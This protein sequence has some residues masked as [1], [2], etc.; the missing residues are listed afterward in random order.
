MHLQEP[1]RFTASSSQGD[2]D[3]EDVLHYHF[4]TKTAG[5]GEILFGFFAIFDGDGGSEAAKF[6]SRRSRRGLDSGQT[7]ITKSVKLSE[8]DFYLPMPPC[9][10][11]PRPQS[12]SFGTL[13][14]T[15][16]SSWA[17][18]ILADRIGSGSPI[19]RAMDSWGLSPI[20]S[21]EVFYPYTPILKYK[22]LTGATKSRVFIL[23]QRQ[24]LLGSV[25]NETKTVL[26]VCIGF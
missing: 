21:Y 7:M 9:G 17:K 19:I 6:A 16:A 23:R 1:L 3:M 2:V 13:N 20:F 11:G 22:R 18:N 8:T 10:T 26:Y 24:D 15:S 14:S 4:E 25:C 5:S 12:A